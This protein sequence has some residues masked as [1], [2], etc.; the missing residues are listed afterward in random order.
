M[1]K[2][3]DKLAAEIWIYYTIIVGDPQKLRPS[4]APYKPKVADET[5]KQAFLDA[6]CAEYENFANLMDDKRSGLDRHKIAA[7]TMVCFSR[8]D[9]LFEKQPDI[10]KAKCYPQQEIAIHVGIAYM[11]DQLNYLL[12]KHVAKIPKYDMPRA[13]SCRIPYAEIMARELYL[14]TEQ[15]LLNSIELANRLFLL[16]YITILNHNLKPDIFEVLKQH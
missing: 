15:K 11:L 6:F 14:A 5:L 2:L 7:I 3:P 8:L 13:F 1:N 10:K 9:G 16:E 12:R 4:I